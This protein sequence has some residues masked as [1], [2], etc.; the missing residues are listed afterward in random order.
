[1]TWGEFKQYID[2]ELAKKKNNNGDDLQIDYIDVTSPHKIFPLE[3]RV[4]DLGLSIYT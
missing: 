4:N 2:R 1:M 3:I